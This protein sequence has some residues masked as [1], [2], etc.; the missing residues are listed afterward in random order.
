MKSSGVTPHETPLQ[1]VLLHF[2][3]N[4]RWSGVPESPVIDFQKTNAAPR[5]EHKR[6]QQPAIPNTAGEK[7]T[8][9]FRSPFPQR[10]TTEEKQVSGISWFAVINY[11]PYIQTGVASLDILMVCLWIFSLALTICPVVYNMTLAVLLNLLF[12]CGSVIVDF[13][14]SPMVFY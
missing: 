4:S 11:S 13:I 14:S 5:G 1:T 10:K 8:V 7:F 6:S 12:H 9:H 2:T 3:A